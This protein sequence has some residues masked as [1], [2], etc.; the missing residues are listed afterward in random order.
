MKALHS[1]LAAAVLGAA[2]ILPTLSAT[3]TEAA[4]IFVAKPASAQSDVVQVRDG[5]YRG[6][7][8]YRHYRHGYRNY[9]G[10]WYP[11]GAFVAGALIGGALAN[12]NRYYGGY[13]GNGYYN[14]YYGGGYYPR[15]YPR[16]YAPRY[17][18]P[19]YYAPERVYYPPRGTAYRQGYRD[20]YRDGVNVRRY[21]DITCTPRLADAGRC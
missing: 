17:Y 11:A 19:R 6:H 7:R 10:W 9:D 2:L 14:S 8:G 16:Y 18:A 5:W 21:G 1:G 20:G 12:S 15:Y 3:P 4:P 13:Y